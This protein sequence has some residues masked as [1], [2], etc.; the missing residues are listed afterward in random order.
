MRDVG[1]LR[2]LKCC[3]G[4]KKKF[5]LQNQF[6]KITAWV[7]AKIVMDMFRGGVVRDI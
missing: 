2:S 5:W 7:R 1:T 4:T 6:T 3:G